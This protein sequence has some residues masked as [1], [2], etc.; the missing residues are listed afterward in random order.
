MRISRESI[1]RKTARE[2]VV[3]QNPVAAGRLRERLCE[4]IKNYQKAPDETKAQSGLRLFA[5]S[6]A[7]YYIRQ[8]RIYMSDGS[9]DNVFAPR[10]KVG[11]AASLQ[12]LDLANLSE[13]DRV[14]HLFS[15]V[16]YFTFFLALSQPAVLDCVDVF[17]PR[18]YNLERIFKEGFN[19]VYKDLPQFLHPVITRPNYLLA[20]AAKL[21]ELT[22]A[23][24]FQASS[25]NKV[26][27]T[28]PFGRGYDRISELEAFVLWLRALDAVGRRNKGT[29]STFSLL[30]SE[31]IATVEKM[32]RNLISNMA[33]SVNAL[34]AEL[35]GC[36]YYQEQP[37]LL[38]KMPVPDGSGLGKEFFRR[39]DGWLKRREYL[40]VDDTHSY[41]RSIYITHTQNKE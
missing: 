41:G 10:I 38:A 30:P 18:N 22:K 36:S 39:L 34:R 21:P 16:G 19:W 5:Q 7:F 13:N 4:A 6:M 23:E 20:D 40:P 15:G 31:W 33:G 17:T 2:I 24:G 26:F 32:R 3:Q 29:Y 1:T 14:L 9:I 37:E 28:H 12:M 35:A 8:M 25:Y 27:L 11:P